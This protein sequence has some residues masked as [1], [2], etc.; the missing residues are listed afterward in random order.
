MQK[1]EIQMIR[2]KGKPYSEIGN[3]LKIWNP[4]KRHRQPFLAHPIS[5][6]L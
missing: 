1:Y 6:E 4:L 3:P 5:P 2:R